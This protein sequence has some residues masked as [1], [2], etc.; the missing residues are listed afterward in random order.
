MDFFKFHSILIRHIL[1]CAI[2]VSCG[3]EENDNGG[4]WALLKLD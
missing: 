4:E 1:E 3:Y 2:Y